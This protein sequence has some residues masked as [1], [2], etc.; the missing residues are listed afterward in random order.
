MIGDSGEGVCSGAG[1]GGE[2]SGLRARGW[3]LG[4]GASAGASM[5]VPEWSSSQAWLDTVEGPDGGAS[6]S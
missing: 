1:A 2:L 5:R 3:V 6:V 4:A